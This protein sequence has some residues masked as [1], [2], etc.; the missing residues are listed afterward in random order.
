MLSNQV[1]AVYVGIS[2][3]DLL[4]AAY[5]EALCMRCWMLAKSVYGMEDEYAAKISEFNYT[6]CCSAGC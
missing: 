5:I 6:G 1:I 3:C 4:V 2:I